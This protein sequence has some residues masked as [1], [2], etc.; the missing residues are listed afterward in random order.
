MPKPYYSEDGITIYH[1]DCRE[2]LA[3]NNIRC[4]AVLTD[5]PYGIDVDIQRYAGSRYHGKRQAPQFEQFAN[6]SE[7]MDMAFLW[8]VGLKQVVFG[9]NNWPQSI[10]FNC[11]RDGWLCWDKR[12]HEVADGIL[13]SP[14]ELACFI[15]GRHYDIFRLQHA[16]AINAD[17]P[18]TPRFHP[19]QKPVRLMQQ[20]ILRF[21]RGEVVCDPFMGSGST[22]LAA[23][24]LDQQSIGIEIEEKYCEIA[25]KRLSQKVLQFP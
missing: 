9:A 11:K 13:G 15:G 14:F 23:K 19:T 2:V 12:I 25:A 8:D 21:F 6:E 24:L 16:G 1:G 17:G 5:P 22:L 18:N 20:I 4:D 10:P 7:P 3:H